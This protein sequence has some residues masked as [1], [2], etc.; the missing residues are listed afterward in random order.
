ML[1]ISFFTKMLLIQV[2]RQNVTKGG[3]LKFLN[4]HCTVYSVDHR[5]K[6]P[7]R[8]VLPRELDMAITGKRI[9]FLAKYKVFSMGKVKCTNLCLKPRLHIHGFLYDSPRF[10]PISHGQK[11]RG[12][13]G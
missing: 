7:V 3:H 4:I 9:P 11:N 12:G 5:F 8:C 2:N 10:T 13:P 6:R 1:I